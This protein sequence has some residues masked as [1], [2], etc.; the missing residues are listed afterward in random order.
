[1][2]FFE[3]TWFCAEKKDEFG[4][5]KMVANIFFFFQRKLETKTFQMH[6]TNVSGD[7]TRLPCAFLESNKFFEKSKKM[8]EK[9][10]FRRKIGFST[11]N[12][13]NKFLILFSR[14]L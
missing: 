3:K 7:K 1:M 13:K 2:E 9:N 14:Q 4:G 10:D 5:L 11:Q 8:E 12:S 6:S